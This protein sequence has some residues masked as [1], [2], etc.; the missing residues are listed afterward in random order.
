MLQG[1]STAV[2]QSTTVPTYCISVY[3]NA[4]LIRA[5]SNVN[6]VMP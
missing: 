6:V 3:L 1:T 2:G 5:G 4:P